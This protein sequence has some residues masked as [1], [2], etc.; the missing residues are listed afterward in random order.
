MVITPEEWDEWKHHHI[1][2]AF[3]SAMKDRREEIKENLVM[4]SYEED[5]YAR[6]A[7]QVLLNILEMSY[8]EFKE[9]IHGK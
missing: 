6:G 5:G 4:G 1:T 2:K 9:E 3:F 8:D 7:A